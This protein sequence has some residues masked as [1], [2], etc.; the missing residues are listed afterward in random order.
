MKHQYIETASS[1]AEVHCR[2]ADV[3]QVK[4]VMKAALSV[5]AL[6]VAMELAVI[7]VGALLTAT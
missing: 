4:E 7:I 6:T 2:R 3:I 5:L 1:V